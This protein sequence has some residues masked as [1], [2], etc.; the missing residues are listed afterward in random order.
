MV[1]LGYSETDHKAEAWQVQTNPQN[2]LQY[3]QHEGVP[4]YRQCYKR[5][6]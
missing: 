6:R 5:T 2:K 1:R 4:R 3:R